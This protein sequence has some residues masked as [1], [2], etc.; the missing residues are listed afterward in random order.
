MLK[1][2]GVKTGDRVT[3]I[4]RF[5]VTLKLSDKTEHRKDIN[6]GTE[7]I[8]KSYVDVVPRLFLVEMSLKVPLEHASKKTEIKTFLLKANSK[9][10]ELTPVYE[11]KKGKAISKAA[12]D[13]EDPPAEEETKTT[14]NVAKGFEWLCHHRSVSDPQAEIRVEKQ[15]E[16]LISDQDAFSRV[17]GLK[18]TINMGLMNLYA[19][20][21]KYTAKDLVVC[22]RQTSKGAWKTEVW[23]NR[24]FLPK[25]LMIVAKSTLLK[26]RHWSLNAHAIVGLPQQGPSTHP[27][28]RN[29]ALDGSPWQVIAAAKSIDLDEHRGSLFWAIPRVGDK[30]QEHNLILGVVTWDAWL[31][32]KLPGGKRRKVDIE[33]KDQPQLPVIVNPKK[34]SVYTPLILYQDTQTIPKE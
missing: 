25:E 33:S 15:W 28:G 5:T 2:G 20:L 26:D 30:A 32:F 18:G 1:S 27:E 8:I 3:V 4:N 19:S 16:N 17:C 11:K 22:H 29:I 7:G 10:L 23:A 9:N 12:K 14:A 21:P 34:I 24:D 13:L 6:H 31:S